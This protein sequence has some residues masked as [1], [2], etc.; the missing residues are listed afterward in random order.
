MRIVMTALACIV[1]TAPVVAGELG[2]ASKGTVLER[3]QSL[4][5]SSRASTIRLDENRTH[6]FAE[7]CP[8]KTPQ[9]VCRR[10]PDGR[11]AGNC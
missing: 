6:R 9:G 10:G 5:Q 7:Y 11:P 8:C 2:T 4:K 3:L 1:L